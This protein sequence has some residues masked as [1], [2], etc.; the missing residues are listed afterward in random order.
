MEVH[1]QEKTT[2]SD[3]LVNIAEFLNNLTPE[4]KGHFFLMLI[5]AV[6]PILAI[7]GFILRHENFISNSSFLMVEYTAAFLLAN[8]IAVLLYLE[9]QQRKNQ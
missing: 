8:D 7:I 4:Q 6:T 1:V 9:N 3:S 5:S 2:Q